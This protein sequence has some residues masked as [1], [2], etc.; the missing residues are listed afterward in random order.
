MR[1]G[2]RAGI[3]VLVTAERSERMQGGDRVLVY[4]ALQRTAQYL[5]L[6]EP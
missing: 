2:K 1:T 4:S 6:F 3:E 5:G